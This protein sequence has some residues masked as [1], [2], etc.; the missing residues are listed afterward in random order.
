MP[1]SLEVGDAA[2]PA[3][4]A[5]R[6]L[7]LA[8]LDQPFPV[9]AAE[10]VGAVPTAV[11]PVGETAIVSALMMIEMIARAETTVVLEA[12]TVFETAV[13]LE[14]AVVS[15]MKIAP[16]LVASEP[17]VVRGE[18]V[19]MTPPERP[20]MPPWKPPPPRAIESV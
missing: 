6:S 18:G 17:F 3:A 14:T 20:A 5:R 7:P 13:V 8:L 1:L 2:G 19:H 9:V 15:K 4:K 11:I 16:A 10:T 12:A